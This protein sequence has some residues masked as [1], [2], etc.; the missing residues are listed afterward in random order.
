MPEVS[1]II[2]CYNQGQFVNEAVQ[3]VLNQTL[4]DF[5]IIIVNDGSTDENTIN[6]LKQYSYPKLKVINTAN[7]GVVQA[8]NT[9]IQNASGRYIL[10]L[11]ADDKIADS[12]LERCVHVLDQNQE[13]GIVYCNA[14]FFGSQNGVWQLPKY[15][16][17]RMLWTNCVFCTAMYRKE[18]WQK[19]NGYNQNMIYGYEDWNF[20]LSFIEN[21]IKV[22]KLEEILFFYRQHNIS[23]SRNTNLIFNVFRIFFTC[24]QLLN[25]H[26]KLYF[27]SPSKIVLLF[28]YHFYVWIRQVIL[29]IIK[30]KI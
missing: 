15:S 18:D 28:G 17:S 2:P 29:Q 14:E 12:Y 16:E 30:G 6:I 27:K 10:P 8:R 3:S 20:W 4:Q 19:V 23:E 5:E 25:N 1:V 22:Y 24:K 21:G 13:T 11:D 7:F 26:K 9:G